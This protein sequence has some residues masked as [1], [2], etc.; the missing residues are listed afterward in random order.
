M[1]YHNYMYSLGLHNL[2]DEGDKFSFRC[3]FCG[4][5]SEHQN[6]RQ[7]YIL[8]I[9]DKPFFYCHKCG[10][11]CEPN[12]SF[13]MFL[14]EMDYSLYQQYFNELKKEMMVNFSKGERSEKVVEF[15]QTE[16][17]VK[18]TFD[19]WL[20]PLSLLDKKHVANEYASLR[21]I[22]EN[23]LN[24]TYY[25][26]GNPFTFFNKIFK[27]EKYKT[28]GQS[29]YEGILFPYRDIDLNYKGFGIRLLKSV[30]D[31]R[32]INLL[33]SDQKFFF[34]E[35]KINRYSD[36]YIVEGLIDKVSVEDNNFIAMLSTNPKIEHGNNIT[37]GK[38]NYIFD[39]EYLNTY[40]QRNIKRVGKENNVFL[41]DR[42][43][44]K[45]K[46]INDLKTKYDL[47]D[48]D[49]KEYIKNNTFS[50][51]FLQIEFKKRFNNYLERIL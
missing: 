4:G 29:L 34:G 41:W 14:K 30:G 39:N 43:Y 38:L 23:H 26:F 10:H 19:D 36:L 35:D 1:N 42:S 8:N 46:D 15:T 37:S 12:N 28:K 25:F 49:I 40:I 51:M 18:T 48:G 3:P 7:A 11:V 2:K 21:R 27:T 44:D 22:T 5:S 31:F 9:F 6:R 17:H 45:A 47:K 13:A 32:F 16:T 33:E 20:T 24:E 50:G